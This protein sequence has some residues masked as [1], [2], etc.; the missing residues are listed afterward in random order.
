MHKIEIIEPSAM[1][2][3][4]F[5][6]INGVA[7]KI[8]SLKIESD[9][10]SRITKVIIEVYHIPYIIVGMIV[11][12]ISGNYL[13]AKLLQ[14]YQEFGTMSKITE[15]QAQEVIDEIKSLIRG[16]EWRQ[17]ELIEALLRRIS[18]GR[19]SVR[20]IIIKNADIEWSRYNIGNKT[21]I[22]EL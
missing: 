16:Y 5:V 13:H 12:H 6:Y 15:E 4:R 9:I 2:S 22:R 20:R 1:D 8:R 10:S 14:T 18:Y 19:E 17:T 7:A 3:T 21:Y 11:K